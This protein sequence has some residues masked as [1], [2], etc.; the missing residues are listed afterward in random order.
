ML[1]GIRGSI[2]MGYER[3]GC[4]VVL[5]DQGN[6]YLAV[7]STQRGQA[8]RTAGLFEK[9]DIFEALNRY[10]QARDAMMI[11]VGAA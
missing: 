8:S 10:G 2:V 1:T 7:V 4:S 5:V 11:V 6:G 9:A 3:D